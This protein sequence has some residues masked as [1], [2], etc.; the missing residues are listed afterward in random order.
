MKPSLNICSRDPQN[1]SRFF[2]GQTLN[3]PEN[4]DLTIY[5]AQRINGIVYRFPCLFLLE[6]LGRNRPPVSIV[7]RPKISFFIFLLVINRLV[8]VGMG[9]P[10]LHFGFVV[11]DLYKPGAEL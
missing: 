4:Q 9:F 5:G 8:E 2:D 3:V 10:Y 6:Q 7:F 1:Y 11:R